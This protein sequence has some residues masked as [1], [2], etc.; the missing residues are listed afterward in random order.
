MG[1]RKQGAG[2]RNLAGLRWQVPATCNLQNF[3]D[4]SP[5]LPATY[6]NSGGIVS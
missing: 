5:L 3:C 6:N 2:S 1:D 4:L